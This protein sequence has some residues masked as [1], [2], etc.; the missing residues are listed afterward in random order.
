MY[1]YSHCEIV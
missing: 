1:M